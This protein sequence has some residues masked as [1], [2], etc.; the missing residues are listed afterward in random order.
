MRMMVLYGNEFDIK[1]IGKLFCQ[2]RGIKIRMKIAC[3]IV[4]PDLK[5]FR[6]MPNRFFKRAVVAHSV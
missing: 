3:N 5:N 6:Q 1:L 2:H 4:G